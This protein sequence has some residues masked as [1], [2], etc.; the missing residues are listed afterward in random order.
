MPPATVCICLTGDSGDY[1][2]KNLDDHYEEEKRLQKKYGDCILRGVKVP[3]V[4]RRWLWMDGEG[5]CLS[6]MIPSFEV[7]GHV[8][9]LVFAL[10]FFFSPSFVHA[11][12]GQ[13]PT[14]LLSL[15]SFKFCF[16][17]L[18]CC[19]LFRGLTTGKLC[20]CRSGVKRGTRRWDGAAIKMKKR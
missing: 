3:G 9:T 17:V 10:D 14:N 12:G 18:A 1:E 13:L 8:G 19:L 6:R 7:Y 2:G 15:F 5:F 20:A 4:V 11:L 16:A